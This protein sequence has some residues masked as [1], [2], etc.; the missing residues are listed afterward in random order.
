V[1]M[2]PVTSEILKVNPTLTTLSLEGNN[3]IG[4]FGKIAIYEALKL[5][6]TITKLELSGFCKGIQVVDPQVK[7][8]AEITS[9]DARNWWIRHVGDKE[10]NAGSITA[11]QLLLIVTTEWKNKEELVDVDWILK[12]RI[13]PYLDK[14]NDNEVSLTEFSNFFDGDSSPESCI[15]KKLVIKR[16]KQELSSSRKSSL[17]KAEL[18]KEEE[19][20]NSEKLAFIES[21]VGRETVFVPRVR[22]ALI[23]SVSNYELTGMSNLVGAEK[24]GE[25]V[26][27]FLKKNS[28]FKSDEIIHLH[29]P[30]IEDIEEEMNKI[31]QTASQLSKSAQHGLF[32]IYY[33]GHGVTEGSTTHIYSPDD[34]F[35]PIE[36]NL[37]NFSKSPNSMF[38]GILDCCRTI[39][40]KGLSVQQTKQPGQLFLLHCSPPNTAALSLQEGSLVTTSF[41]KHL[42]N[43]TKPFPECLEDWNKGKAEI[44]DNLIGKP[45]LFLIREIHLPKSG[46]DTS[47]LNTMTKPELSTNEDT[48]KKENE[49][50]LLKSGNDTSGLHTLTKPELSTNEDTSLKK[51]NEV[52]KNENQVL[53][54]MIDVLK[55][56]EAMMNDVLKENEV[57]KNEM[58]L[59]KKEAMRSVVQDETKS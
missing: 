6:S 42:Q 1:M 8:I 37:R 11:A 5:N 2:E 36:D 22:R 46:N 9:L 34:E 52:L 56:K 31:K 43:S 55:N 7:L 41:L 15:T 44:V 19:Q 40:K 59:M 49:R 29:N 58:E 35:Y 48:L 50:Y 16:K 39:N 20:E 30:W 38:I 47:G 27:N 13:I 3:K 21:L 32:F 51:E 4:Y 54:I 33:S 45:K 57:L 28:I 26:K 53:K 12:N 23:I 18:T 25:S 17:V 10:M 14:N 24:D